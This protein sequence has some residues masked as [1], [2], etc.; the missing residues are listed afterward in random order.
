MSASSFGPRAGWPCCRIPGV[1]SF[2]ANRI[3]ILPL[4]GCRFPANPTCAAIASASPAR[5]SVPK[6]RQG[7]G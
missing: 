6:C 2:V 4:G 3:N 1:G 5:Q 7:T